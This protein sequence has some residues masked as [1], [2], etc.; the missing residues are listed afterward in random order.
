[1]TKRTPSKPPVKR[2][3]AAKQAQ[4]QKAGPMQDK[5]TG[6]GG[7]KNLMREALKESNS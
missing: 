4:D 2:N 6:K 1:M 7:A 3:L 5:R